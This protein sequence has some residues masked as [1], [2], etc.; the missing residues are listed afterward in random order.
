M[1]G[2]SYLDDL[3]S[4]GV[5]TIFRGSSARL[6]GMGTIVE[7]EISLGALRAFFFKNTVSLK[8]FRLSVYLLTFELPVFWKKISIPDMDLHAS[9]PTAQ[10]PIR[11][12]WT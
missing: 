11:K 7:S 1:L 10:I 12:L 6:V 4:N 3:S 5:G 8:S 2:E 9:D